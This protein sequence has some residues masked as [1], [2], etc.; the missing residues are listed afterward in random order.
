M[1]RGHSTAEA[2]AID[3]PFRPQRRVRF[4]FTAHPRMGVNGR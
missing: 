3:A 1:A 2:E 4:P